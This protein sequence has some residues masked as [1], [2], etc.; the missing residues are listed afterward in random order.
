MYSITVRPCAKSLPSKCGDRHRHR[1][2]LSGEM[3]EELGLPCEISVAP[4]TKA[5]HRT[6]AVNAYA[7]DVVGGSAREPLDASR[8][9][10][11]E[12]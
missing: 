5:T 10:A 3:L 1:Q 8:V 7:P 4:R 6:F 9:L 2:T 11:P 12:R